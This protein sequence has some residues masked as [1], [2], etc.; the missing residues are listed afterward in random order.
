MK[1]IARFFHG[2][3]LEM[4]RVRWPKTSELA[5]YSVATISFIIFFA[6][7]FSLSQMLAAFFKSIL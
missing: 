1:T 4:K 7:F 2:V 3:G 5:R 6:A